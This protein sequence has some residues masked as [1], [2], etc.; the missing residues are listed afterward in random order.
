[1]TMRSSRAEVRNPVLRLKA[2]KRIFEMPRD[3]Q[4][5]WYDILK[6]MSAEARVE[7]ERLWRKPKAPMAGYHKALAVYAGHFA[8]V[9]GRRAR[10]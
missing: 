6:E 3:Q 1:M 2:T 9:I 4:E 7:A 10:A 8:K 5:I